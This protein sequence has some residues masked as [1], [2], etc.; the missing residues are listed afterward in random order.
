VSDRRS[1]PRSFRKAVGSAAGQRLPSCASPPPAAACWGGGLPCA[2]S[3]ARRAVAARR[4]VPLAPVAAHSLLRFVSALTVQAT[5]RLRPLTCFFTATVL[6]DRLQ[7]RPPQMSFRL[8]VV[9]EAHASRPDGARQG[10]HGCS[11]A[12]CRRR[13]GGRPLQGG[14][15][16]GRS[17]RPKRAR[18][19]SLGLLH[20][21]P[22]S[23]HPPPAGPRP[24]PSTH[25]THRCTAGP[26]RWAAALAACAG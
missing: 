11:Q 22:L 14:S 4:A 5:R 26:R 12:P 8:H 7:L 9:P 3:Q 13:G 17:T 20:A 16:S 2:A 1:R 21:P 24:K 25:L 18:G 23:P 19:C 15:A 10:V 6:M